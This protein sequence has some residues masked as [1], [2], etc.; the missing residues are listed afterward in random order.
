M[1]YSVSLFVY[2]ALLLIGSM[3]VISANAAKPASN[4]Y[5]IA[6]VGDISGTSIRDSIREHNPDLVVA[7]G[8]LGYE[9]T[10][11]T[12]KKDYG[13][14]NL[15]CVVGNHDSAEDSEGDPIVKETLEYCGD[16]WNVKVGKTT[17]LFGFNTNGNLDN[18]LAAA[19]QSILTGNQ[20]CIRNVPQTMLY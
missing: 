3:A 17:M 18:Q 8:D 14:F 20:E 12:F 15:K 4:I 5:K 1:N 7:L 2:L 6:I 11:S 16:W 10:L 19:E 13:I 9:S